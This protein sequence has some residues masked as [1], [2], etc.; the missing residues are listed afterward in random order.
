[1][2]DA[3]PRGADYARLVAVPAIWG[4]TF[5]GGKIVVTKW[6]CPEGYDAYDLDLAGL[7]ETCD[8]VVSGVDFFLSGAATELQDATDGAGQV[9]FGPLPAGA[10]YLSE[11]QPTGYGEPI[12]VC[13]LLVGN[14]AIS[15]ETAAELVA[16][17][18]DRRR[19]VA[20]VESA[21]TARRAW[22]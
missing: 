11:G 13:R 19:N 18:T 4:G 21:R 1:M 22:Q 12:V 20:A 2:S 3:R 8:E 14:G 15:Y 16:R 5:V 9:A 7:Y 10:Y 17:S 6:V